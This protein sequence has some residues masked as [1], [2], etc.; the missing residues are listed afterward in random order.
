MQSL[1]VGILTFGNK[2]GRLLVLCYAQLKYVT[3]FLSNLNLI[4]KW[5]KWNLRG[6][7]ISKVFISLGHAQLILRMTDNSRVFVMT[8][9]K[10]T[11]RFQNFKTCNGNVNGQCSWSVENILTIIILRIIGNKTEMQFS[12][13]I[14]PKI[15]SSAAVPSTESTDHGLCCISGL[16]LSCF[17]YLFQCSFISK[18]CC[19]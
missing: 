4:S 14:D 2:S 8:Q 10:M 12:Y 17:I 1:P 19:Y 3:V 5:E 6:A 18:I 15:G 11:W 7:H 9:Y 13:S 16:V